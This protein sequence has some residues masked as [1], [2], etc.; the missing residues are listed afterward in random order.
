MGLRSTLA[1]L[2]SAPLLAVLEQRLREVITRET[3]S[4]GYA[5]PEVVRELNT[6]VAHARKAVEELARDLAAQQA[7]VRTLHEQFDDDEPEIDD[8]GL[9]LAGLDARDEQLR[10]HLDRVT[11][12]ARRLA[13]QVTA[14]RTE[15]DRAERKLESAESFTAQASQAAQRSASAVSAQAAATAQAEPAPPAPEDEPASEPAAAPVDPDDRGCGVPDCTGKHR[16]RGFCARHYQMWKR[17]TLLGFVAADGLV[18][19]DEAGPRY[20]V[21]PALAARAAAWV[22]D[23]LLVEGK[24]TAARAL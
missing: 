22:D 18:Q 2:L 11:S 14:L 21:D 12:D 20:V 3:D 16:A 1:S 9:R 24:P 23:R 15:L 19:F 13:D 5:D 8:V 17:G 4:R 6:H 10:A 7:A